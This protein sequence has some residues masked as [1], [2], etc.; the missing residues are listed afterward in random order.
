MKQI[1]FAA[2][3]IFAFSSSA[4][5]TDPTNDH[6]TKTIQTDASSIVWTGKKVTGSHTGTIK[7]KSGNLEFHNGVLKGGMITI[8][9]NSMVCTDLDKSTAPKLEGHLK[10][11]DFFGVPSHPTA[12]LKITNASPAQ[13][14]GGY[15]ITA[16]ITIKGI[17]KSITF[18]ALV[19][20]DEASSKVTIN[21]TDFGIK[22]GSG[23]FFDNLGDKMIYDNFD[24]E[25]TLKY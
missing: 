6:E 20:S 10:S 18:S 25:L 13:A 2:F 14:R 12:T 8:D 4:N 17:T 21:R 23:S 19:G 22:Y 7:V 24:L 15:D 16:D 9:M 5:T 3:M 1:L 11:D